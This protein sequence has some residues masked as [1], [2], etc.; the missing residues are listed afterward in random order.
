MLFALAVLVVAVS[1]TDPDSALLLAQGS[2]LGI[3][4]AIVAAVL[5]RVSARPVAATVQV[6]GSSRALERSV[7]EMYQRP[8]A[9]GSQPSTATNPLL[10]GSTP[11]LET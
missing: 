7:T 2:T 8:P 4:L 1:M 10:P 11:E 3:V 9:H 6:R 5:A